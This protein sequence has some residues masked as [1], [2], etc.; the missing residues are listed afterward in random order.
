M[1][2]KMFGSLEWETA[3]F[4]VW[5][6]ARAIEAAMKNRGLYFDPNGSNLNPSPRYPRSMRHGQVLAPGPVRAHPSVAALGLGT[7]ERSVGAFE[8]ASQIA[9]AVLGDTG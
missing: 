3:A 9:P 5:L 7:V 1:S 6:Q 4:S 8:Q 2:A